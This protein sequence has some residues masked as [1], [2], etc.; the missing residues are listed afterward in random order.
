MALVFTH[1][2]RRSE[3]AFPSD[4]DELQAVVGRQL[5]NEIKEEH[6]YHVL[7]LFSLAYLYKQTFAIPG[8]VFMNIVSGALFGGLSSPVINKPSAHPHLTSPLPHVSK[9]VLNMT[10]PILGIPLHLF[11]MSVLIG[12]VPYNYLCVQTG[13]ILSELQTLTTVL[14]RSQQCYCTGNSLPPGNCPVSTETEATSQNRIEIRYERKK[15]KSNKMPMWEDS[16]DEASVAPLSEA[17]VA[18]GAAAFAAESRK[19]AAKEGSMMTK[20][21]KG[22]TRAGN[23]LRYLDPTTTQLP[24]DIQLDLALNPST[25]NEASVMA[26]S[27]AEIRKHIANDEK[28]SRLGWVCIPLSVETYG[29]W[30]EEAGDRLATRIATRTGCPKSSAVSGLYGRLSIGLVRANSMAFN[31]G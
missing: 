2:P 18:H 3:L 9:L 16:H 27:A 23:T 24:P 20:Q 5:K 28:C 30:G 19:H 7:L 31:T 1:Y 13:L 4:F 10:S 12:L 6:F 22:N 29:C 17:S 11:F 21:I 14:T 26:G 25:L 8:S 15:H